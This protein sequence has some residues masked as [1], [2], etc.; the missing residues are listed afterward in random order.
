MRLIKLLLQLRLFSAGEM[1]KV[2]FAFCVIPPLDSTNIVINIYI[3]IN[4]K[5]SLYLKDVC[6]LHD[7]L[8]TINLFFVK[9]FFPRLK[10]TASISFHLWILERVVLFHSRAA[11]EVEWSKAAS[12]VLVS[13]FRE[14]DYL[15]DNTL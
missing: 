3:Y 7:Y 5:L 1:T 4:K 2:S 15:R 12:I 11:R 14:G 13:N 6:I 8:I 10:R 9:L